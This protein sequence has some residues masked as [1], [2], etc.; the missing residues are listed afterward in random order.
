MPLPE[1]FLQTLRER[2]PIVDVISPYVNLR[3]RGS[4]YVGR[5]PFH[6]EKTPSFTVY[7][8]NDSFYCYGCKVGGDAITFIK[9]A[10]NLDYIDAVK[11]LA[12]RA[13]LEMPQDNSYND[14][15]HKLRTRVYEANREAA[16]FYYRT[17][18][19]SQGRAGMNYLTSR[20]LAKETITSFGL[21]YAPDSWDALSGYLLS[22]GFSESE[23][24]QA[25][26]AVKNNRGGIYDRFRNRVMFPIIDVR[27]NVVAFGG[28]VLGDELPKYLNT[29]DTPAFKK[30]SNLFALNKAKSNIK[31][32]LIL[33]EGYM[34]VIALHQAGF[35]NAVATLGT[36][37]TEQQAGI[38]RRYA[39]VVYICY[40]SD[41]AGRNA[42]DRAI[43]ILRAKGLKVKVLTVPEG[44]DPDEYLRCAKREYPPS[45]GGGQGLRYSAS[46]LTDENGSVRTAVN[47][48]L[49]RSIAFQK[50]IDTAPTDIDYRLSR[51][52]EGMNLSV[53]EDQAEYLTSAARLLSALDNEIEANVYAGKLCEEFGVNRQAFD[54]RVKT[55]RTAQRKSGG[56]SPQG[57]QEGNA[58]ADSRQSYYA[59]SANDR[60]TGYTNRTSSGALTHE[61]GKRHKAF[62]PSISGADA[63]N[64][65]A[66]AAEE[67]LILY[68]MHHP[69]ECERVLERLPVEKIVTDSGKRVYEIVTRRIS[70]GKSVT[71]T[72]IFNEDEDAL[73]AAG[74]SEPERFSRLNE[75]NGAEESKD[76]PREAPPLSAWAADEQAR[77]S[78]LLGEY[79]PRMDT[80]KSCDDYIRII[81]EEKSAISAED[82]SKMSDADIDSMLKRK[83]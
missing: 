77:Y 35:T 31:D 50:L 60:D 12:Q 42:T 78:Q 27:A 57:Y 32:S 10:E 23:L 28:R 4:N 79:M 73:S 51:M 49:D 44:K 53:A 33:C 40:D 70:E 5:C 81:L 67:R 55:M 65:R 19:S 54:S 24:V 72:D 18:C 26:L 13:G 76:L 43:D 39:P 20:A 38:L 21:G 80:R 52:R 22:K 3:R 71:L 6:N 63:P 15:T 11:F 56:D 83:K 37:L 48:E 30:S 34:D 17:L 68:L 14:F 25:N 69:D 2:S 41:N 8:N 7:T 29:S 64:F 9:K 62:V 59:S 75:D 66:R 16:R 46:A 74:T 36:S 58:E 47:Y 61:R 82:M 1:E 45:D